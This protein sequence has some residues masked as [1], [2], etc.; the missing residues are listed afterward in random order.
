YT[1]RQQLKGSQPTVKKKIVEHKP[2][3]LRRT[4][5]L[6]APL[7]RL[8]KHYSTIPSVNATA[9]PSA[10]AGRAKDSSEAL[11]SLS[12]LVTLS[13]INHFCG[14]QHTGIIQSSPPSATKKQIYITTNLSKHCE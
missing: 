4:H 6:P 10:Y 5:S 1:E 3:P 11:V 9:T 13:N 2:G 8:H 7:G 12:A 14:P